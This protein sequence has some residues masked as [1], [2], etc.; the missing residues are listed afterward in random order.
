MIQSHDYQFNCKVEAINEWTSLNNPTDVSEAN[1]FLWIG[2][3]QHI[4]KNLKPNVR[5]ISHSNF[6][7]EI[8][9]VNLR[10]AIVRPGVFN[11]NRLK[12]SILD[13][14]SS[15]SQVSDSTPNEQ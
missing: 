13:A 8:K 10:A 3:T 6:L 15:S 11:L 4:I 7:Q 9:Q 12:V 5:K 2:K 1:S 14:G